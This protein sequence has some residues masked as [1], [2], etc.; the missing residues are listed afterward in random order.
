M[1]P[2]QSERYDAGVDVPADAFEEPLRAG[3]LLAN[4]EIS[5]WIAGGW[6]LDV[7]LGRRSRDHADVD[8]AV[9][10]KDQSSLHG[11]LGHDWRFMAV[12]P[13]LGPE[14][15]RVWRPGEG[16]PPAIHEIHAERGGDHAEFLLEETS[17]DE[18]VYRRDDRIR[19]PLEQIGTRSPLG[20]PVIAPD[21]VLLFKAKAPREQDMADLAMMLP[22][23]QRTQ[24][25]WLRSA[26]GT[27]HAHSPFLER[28]P[29][30]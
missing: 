27:A 19:R 14:T 3:H 5:W 16:L 22:F 9:L 18:W 12:D 1:S 7:S 6:A 17:G 23:L 28:L 2:Q 25:S 8:I 30:T 20:L 21:I 24:V 15:R 13:T 29:S 10:R 11:S 4:L 26:I